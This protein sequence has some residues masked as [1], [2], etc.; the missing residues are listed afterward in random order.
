L[1][2]SQL[3][4]VGGCPA[5]GKGNDDDGMNSLKMLPQPGIVSI[6]QVDSAMEWTFSISPSPNCHFLSDLSVIET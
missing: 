6:L 2:Q 5:A 3:K 1:K 4:T